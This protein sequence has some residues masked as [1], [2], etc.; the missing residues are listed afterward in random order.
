M[1]EKPAA[2]VEMVYKGSLSLIRQPPSV[3]RRPPLFASLLFCQQNL[4]PAAFVSAKVPAGGR[5]EAGR[6]SD[7]G[8][9]R[10]SDSAIAPTGNPFRQ[11]RALHAADTSPGGGGKA[12]RTRNDMGDGSLLRR[13]RRPR[14]PVKVKREE[15]FPERLLSL[16]SFLFSLFFRAPKILEGFLCSFTI[17][18]TNRKQLYNQKG[19]NC[20]HF[21]PFSEIKNLTRI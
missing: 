18:Y 9:G 7:A 11:R 3:R 20:K 10:R 2:A 21:R 14:R 12:N 17:S 13:G 1:R 6:L 16:F 19:R 15:A 8:A 5:T 4:P